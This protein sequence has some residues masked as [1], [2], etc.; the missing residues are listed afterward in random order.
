MLAKHIGELRVKLELNQGEFGR[1]FA[2][3][4]MAVSRWERGGAVRS[5]ALIQ[6]ALLAHRSG[7]DAWQFLNAVGLS[8]KD[9]RNAI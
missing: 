3:S 7:L 2:V 6:M 8:R 5:D 4:A 1:L 9:A